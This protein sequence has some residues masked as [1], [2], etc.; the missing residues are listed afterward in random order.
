MAVRTLAAAGDGLHPGGGRYT[1]MQPPVDS[2]RGPMFALLPLVVLLALATHARAEPLNETEASDFA[3]GAEAYR[4]DAL[5]EA[6]RIWLPLAEAGHADAQ[7][8]LGMLCERDSVWVDC[9]PADALRWYEH[10][11][12]AG[13]KLAQFNLGNAYRRGLGT[14]RDEALARE[15]LGRAA[16]QGLVG[17][18]QALG[19]RGPATP[20]PARP[21]PAMEPVMPQPAP[22][23]EGEFTLQ[24]GASPDAAGLRAFAERH[25]LGGAARVLGPVSRPDGSRHFVLVWGRFP[26]AREAMA[27]RSGLPSGAD[28]WGPWPR[29]LPAEAA[30]LP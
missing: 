10:A 3:R 28:A 12:R 11:A 24:I 22:A 2:P 14:S 1:A 26:S 9:G 15:W 17:A 8:A 20:A 23:G 18:G 5:A 4:R 29:R 19:A 6:W 16:G 25:A 30:S 21:T 13:H 27:A 7:F